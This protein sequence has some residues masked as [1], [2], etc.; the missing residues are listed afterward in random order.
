LR[1][2]DDEMMRRLDDEMMRRLD[3]EMMRRLDDEMIGSTSLFQP[4]IIQPRSSQ[5]L[6]GIFIHNFLA[7]LT[8]FPQNDEEIALTLQYVEENC[9]EELMVVF[10][11]ILKDKLLSSYFSPNV[12]VLNETSILFPDGNLMRPD[13]VVF[14]EERV[15]VID[16]KT[17]APNA[18]HKEQID[19]Y[20]AAIRAM[21]YEEVE[22][23]VLYI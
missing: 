9:K 23:L 21:G 12:K 6:H 17:G 5:Q 20:C 10:N 7:S 15:A 8:S 22:G 1:K 11:R 16:Y 13:R 14:L 19:K 3:D 2:L 4:L 18:L